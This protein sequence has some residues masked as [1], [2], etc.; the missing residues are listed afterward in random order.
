MLFPDLGWQIHGSVELIIAL[1]EGSVEPTTRNIAF[2]TPWEESNRQ[3][4]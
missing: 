4:T 1:G 3:N 2:T